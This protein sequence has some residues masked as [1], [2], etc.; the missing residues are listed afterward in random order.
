MK[1][2]TTDST[3][4]WTKVSHTFDT[5]ADN[6]PGETELARNGKSLGDPHCEGRCV[7]LLFTHVYISEGDYGVSVYKV[8]IDHPSLKYY[9]PK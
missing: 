3:M 5:D 8:F 7:I 4:E 1:M 9:N 2:E 6:D